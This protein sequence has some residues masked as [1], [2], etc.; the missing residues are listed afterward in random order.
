MQK[1]DISDTFFFA[2]KWAN[3]NEVSFSW[4][5]VS[6]GKL[7]EASETHNVFTVEQLYIRVT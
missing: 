4:K 7:L 3:R 6:K 2:P 1:N 5:D